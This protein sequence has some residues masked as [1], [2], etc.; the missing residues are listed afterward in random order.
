MYETGN[1][2][3]GEMNSVCMAYAAIVYGQCVNGNARNRKQP[4]RV[5]IAV[6]Q[7]R[8]NL[9]HVR[10]RRPGAPT[11]ATSAHQGVD[12]RVEQELL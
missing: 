10:T 3:T 5:R 9:I 2:L 8:E 7:Q 6:L 4:I 11:L 12:E 1:R